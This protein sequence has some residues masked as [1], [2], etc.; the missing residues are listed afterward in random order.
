MDFTDSSSEATFR[1][2]L[3][4]WLH[5]NLPDGWLDGTVSYPAHREH[6][7]DFQRAWQSKLF[8]AG[9]AGMTWPKEY[10]GRDA[11]AFE[12]VIYLEEM[13]RVRAPEPLGVIGLNMAGPT[14]IVHGTQEQKTRY[15]SKILSGEEIWC[16]GFSEPDAGSDLA[17]LQTRA[18][19]D[20]DEYVVTGQKVWSSYAHIADHCILV[21]RTDP[22]AAQ[23]AG[24]SYLLVDMHSPGID[25]RPI[26]QITGD[27]EFNEIFFDEVR[28]PASNIVESEGEG[29]RVAMTTLMHERGTL[30][31]ALQVR[32][33]LILDDLVR[34]AKEISPNGVR[35]I[36]RIDVRQTLGQFETEVEAMRQTA[37]RSIST[38]AKTGV[39]GPEGSVLKLHWSEVNQRMTEYAWSV[40]GAFSQIDA[41][42]R[43]SI[44]DGKWQYEFLRSRG[45]TIEAG[46]SEILRNIVSERVLGLPRS[47]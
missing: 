34:L 27:P 41:G 33:R 30:G 21:V 14:I 38:F 46:T 32:A 11:S 44:G 7:Y 19:R 24:L 43:H 25:V 5:A 1:R 42:S 39:P 3:H 23:H 31:I 47:R 17:G 16:Q 12:T 45:N 18:V 29:W 2:G 36:D 6:R 9:Y 37:Y 26:V 15:L 20:G 13:A 35:A 40:L 10:G 8:N 28:V 4:D 22:D